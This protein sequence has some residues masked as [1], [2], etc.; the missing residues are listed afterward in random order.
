ML[1]LLAGGAIAYNV[2]KT[3]QGPPP[4][5][6]AKDPLLVQGRQIYQARCLSCHGELGR[7]DGAIAKNLSGPPVG[8]FTDATWKH[9]DKPEQVVGVIARGGQGSAM[10]AW[11]G[12]LDPPEINAV[13]AY[14]FYLAGKPVP[15]VL[16]K[17]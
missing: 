4:V 13:A 11:A 6:I 5:E 12:V 9:G 8:N 16:R 10:S 1:A 17:P 7:G 3:P 14:V 2:A 15:E